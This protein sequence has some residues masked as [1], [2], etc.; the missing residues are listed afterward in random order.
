MLLKREGKGNA[1]V[2]KI[3]QSPKPKKDGGKKEDYLKKKFGPFLLH[4]K[5][6]T[7]KRGI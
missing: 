7:P 6:G 2:E 1:S 3:S 5:R 4:R